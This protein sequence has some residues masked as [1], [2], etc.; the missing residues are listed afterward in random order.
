MREQESLKHPFFFFF[1]KS[2]GGHTQH[3]EVPRLGGELE[4]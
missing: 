1:F 4:L 3:I 2:F